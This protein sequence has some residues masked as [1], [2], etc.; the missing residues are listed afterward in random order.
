M[1]ASTIYRIRILLNRLSGTTY[2]PKDKGLKVVAVP[3]KIKNPKIKFP[4]QA[5]LP[6]WNQAAKL[7][8]RL[9]TSRFA[10]SVIGKGTLKGTAEAS[11]WLN[12]LARARRGLSEILPSSSH[13]TDK[14]VTPK[15]VAFL[16]GGVGLGGALG[17]KALSSE[18]AQRVRKEKRYQEGY[19]QLQSYLEAHPELAG[20]HL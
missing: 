6:G 13:L 5:A 7:L 12:N 8:S 18:Q 3:V 16:A 10:K 15:R 11:S 2:D 1:T 20:Y 4:K 19:E 9:P 17:A 14:L